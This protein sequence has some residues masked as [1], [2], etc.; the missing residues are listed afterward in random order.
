MSALQPNDRTA[1]ANAIASVIRREARIARKHQAQHA[2]LLSDSYGFEQTRIA[3]MLEIPLQA[4]A[5]L[6]AAD[7]IHRCADCAFGLHS[8]CMGP[9][10]FDHE[11]RPTPCQCACPDEA[12]GESRL[13]PLRLPPLH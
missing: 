13:T 5:R 1:G 3:E 9:L 10:D 11:G 6:L 7:G 2:R 8:S 4:V 12:L